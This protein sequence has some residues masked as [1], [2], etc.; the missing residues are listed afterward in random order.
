MSKNKLS[1]VNCEARSEII[2]KIFLT[3]GFKENSMK[4]ILAISD[5]GDLLGG[6]EHSFIDL[7]VWLKNNGFNPFALVP[8]SGDVEK[9]LVDAGIWT[10]AFYLPRMR[11]WRLFAIIAVFL[12][13]LDRKSTLLNSS[14]ES[15]YRMRSAG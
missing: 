4:N 10:E 9:R 11:P 12:R 7:L 2:K 6:G 15:P 1:S 3:N 13:G 8:F 5:N 14:H